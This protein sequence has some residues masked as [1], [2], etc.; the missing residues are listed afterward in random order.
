MDSF[1]EGVETTCFNTHLLKSAS[2]CS[3]QGCGITSDHCVSK[4]QYQYW[5]TLVQ[6]WVQSPRNHPA[7]G[8]NHRIKTSPRVSQLG[9]TRGPAPHWYGNCGYWLIALHLQS[10]G[11]ALVLPTNLREFSQSRSRPLLGPSPCWIYANQIARFLWSSY[12]CLDFTP[13]YWVLS[14]A[15]N[16]A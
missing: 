2:R 11:C 3:W 6:C 14:V 10:G 1:N 12:Q 16:L 15:A 5:G 4:Y 7:D 13:T 9:H 8:W